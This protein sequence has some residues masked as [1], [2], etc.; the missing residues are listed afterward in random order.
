M[1]YQGNIIRPPSEAD[2]IILQVTV[3]CS[4]NRCT[5]C[6]A[7]RDPEQ[8]FQIKDEGIIDLDLEFATQYCRKLKTVFLADGDALV[9]P[10]QRLLNLF[11]R[12]RK[13][14]PWVRRISLYANCRSILKRSPNELAA[15]KAAGLGR[16]YM[17]LESGCEQVLLEIKKGATAAEMLAA[18]RRVREAEIFLSVTCLLGI[19]GT[20][21]SQ[22]HAED[23]AAVL[24]QMQPNQIAVLTLM[25]LDNTELGR[26]VHEGRFQLPDQIG[27]FQELRTMLARL[28]DFRCQF[29]ANHASNYFAL[30]GRLP[31]DREHFLAT[32]DQ[33]LAGTARLK[34]EWLRG[35]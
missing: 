29:Q 8:K 34:P 15:L 27:L 31:K 35:L 17:G 13:E 10:Q 11:R 26:A 9:I 1:H 7:Y 2:S 22:Q 24:S 30:A 33:A 23:T 20:V 4:H 19:G 18:G 12:I 28:A 21:Y 6:G 5:F 14:L 16:I 3:G 25:L 32:I